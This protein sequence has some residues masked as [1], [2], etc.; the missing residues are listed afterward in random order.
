M[1][2]CGK[3]VLARVPLIIIS[4]LR[5]TPS[6]L[7][8]LLSD[9]QC[10]QETIKNHSY[11]GVDNDVQDTPKGVLEEGVDNKV[12]VDQLR[13]L[14]PLIYKFILYLFNKIL[15]LRQLICPHIERN[16]YPFSL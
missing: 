10:L 7:K 5:I 6:A 16:N 8:A 3:P 2:Y 13:D 12:D 11:Q 15:R 9:C 1:A 4:F 14:A